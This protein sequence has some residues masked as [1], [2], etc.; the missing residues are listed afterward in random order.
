MDLLNLKLWGGSPAIYVLASLPDDS[1]ACSC[2]SITAVKSPLSEYVLARV[3][4]RV[5]VGKSCVGKGE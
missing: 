3:V 4:P 5:C 2:L 1:D